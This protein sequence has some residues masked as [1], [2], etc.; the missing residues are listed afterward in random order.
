MYYLKDESTSSTDY[1]F[2]FVNYFFLEYQRPTK[3]ILEY[4]IFL[5][6]WAPCCILQGGILRYRSIANYC[7]CTLLFMVLVITLIMKR[8]FH[9]Y[10]NTLGS[11]WYASWPYACSFKT[12]GWHDCA[13]VPVKEPN[14]MFDGKSWRSSSF[15][16]VIQ[17][18]FTPIIDEKSQQSKSLK[19]QKATS[20]SRSLLANQLPTSRSKIALQRSDDGGVA[21][22]LPLEMCLRFS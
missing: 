8:I 22:I 20:R 18:S 4:A 3:Q 5:E 13:K 11:F 14:I 6:L 2:I 21:T 10:W 15:V 1:V 9:Y 16:V 7:R 17:V 19:F 12:G